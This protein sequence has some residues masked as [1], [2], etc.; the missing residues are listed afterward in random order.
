MREGVP[1]GMKKKKRMIPHPLTDRQRE[2]VRMM[3]LESARVQD[4]AAALGVHRCTV[5]R[6]SQYPE[7]DR[8]WER[9]HREWLREYREQ[10]R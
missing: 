7:W 1:R 4:V 5:W 9:L 8:E 3:F 10:Q 6:W 2:A